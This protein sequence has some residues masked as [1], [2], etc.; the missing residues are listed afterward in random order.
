V[1]MSRIALVSLAVSAHVATRG[2]AET[3]LRRHEQI[4]RAM[5]S[6]SEMGFAQIDAAGRVTLAN[7]RFCSIAGR[8]APELLQM[9]LQD[10]IDPDD[11]PGMAESIRHA[12]ANEEA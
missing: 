4:L 8:S 11:M 1:F 7:N 12:L 5:F 2:R 3:R 10:L 6:Q 9:H